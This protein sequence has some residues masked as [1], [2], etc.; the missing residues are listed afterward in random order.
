MGPGPIE[1]LDHG[2]SR[3]W[4]FW[5]MGVLEHPKK[6]EPDGPKPPWSRGRHFLILVVFI[7]LTFAKC[8]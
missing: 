3:L 6:F 4:K 2:S 5:N 7:V 1:A 8:E